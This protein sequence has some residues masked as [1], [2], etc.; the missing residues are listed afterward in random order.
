MVAIVVSA[1]I[2]F[3]SA[4][5]YAYV[6]YLNNNINRVAVDGGSDRPSDTSATNFLLA[7][8]DTRDGQDPGYQGTGA[9]E[10]TGERSDSVLL[11]HLAAKTNAVTVL[12]F[13]RDSYVDIPAYTDPSTH[14]TTA[15]HHDKLNSSFSE[16]GPS[17]LVQTIEKLSGLRVDHFID[18]DFSQFKNIVNSLGGVEV[19]LTQKATDVETGI[20][21]PVGTYTING[22]QALQFVRQ[23]YNLPLGDLSRINRQQRLLSSIIRKLTSS[24]TLLNPDKLNGFLTSVSKSLTLDDNTDLEDLIT[25]GTRVRGLQ[26]SGVQFLTLPYSELGHDFGGDIGDALVIDAPKATALFAALRNDTPLNGSALTPS[27]TPAASGPALTVAPNEIT[28]AVENGSGVSGRASSVS[29]ALQAIGFRSGGAS[30]AAATATTTVHYPASLSDSAATVAAALPG[31]VLMADS[32][33]SVV[34]VVLGANY[35]DV[36]PVT[37]NG[38]QY[39]TATTPSAA[40]AASGVATGSATAAPITAANADCGY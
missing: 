24:G 19:C 38:K 30:N 39:G 33:V 1:L 4:G 9:S 29:S 37:V 36:Q 17:L 18:V 31:S 32:T 26:A 22:D 3:T 13:P 21:L 8:S 7:G 16:G 11:V 12:S 5:G 40:P 2:V 28:V 35:S 34:T 27:A 14:K 15:E 25:L 6:R 10:V 20:N 23:R